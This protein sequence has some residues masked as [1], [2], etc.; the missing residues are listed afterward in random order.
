MSAPAIGALP[1]VL[2]ARVV[3]G[4]GGGPDRTIL[5]S[6]R[7]LERHGYAST[8]LYLRPPAD[9]GFAT[10][11]ERAKLWGAPLA[12]IDDRGAFDPS[13]VKRA[14]RVCRSLQPAIWHGHDYK[15]N[16]LGL[17]LK[18]RHGFRL[19]TT[20]HG[21]VNY[22]WKTPLFYAIDKACL[23]RYE[24][25]ICVS[26]GEF[27]TCLEARVPRSRLF[28]VHNSVDVDRFR[29]PMIGEGRMTR[30]D[31]R[32]VVGGIGRLEDEKG[33]DVLIRVIAALVAD[34]I[35]LELRLAGEGK[36]RTELGE[37]A[38]SLGIADRVQFC[39]FVDSIEEFHR[40]LDVFV[41]SS[42]RE[43]LPN[44]LLEAMATGT[45]SV[46]TDLPG[47]PAEIASSKGLLV[48]REAAVEPL[49]AALREFVEDAEKRERAGVAG[50][51]TIE[52]EFNFARRMERVAALYDE[53]LSPAQEPHRV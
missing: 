7:H 5:N 42:R 24:Q 16:L 34:G 41:L 38:T 51:G 27:D 52:R 36:C 40:D 29:P 47:L 18:R 37:L 13:V 6:P 44:A 32:L 48:A 23:R 39:G 11:E 33:F 31:Q 50:R 49:E 30:E 4:A 45:A 26:Q 46:T 21:W 8:C 15:S 9:E 1:H 12:A 35:D 2:H 14:D 19:V 43:G 17:L 25:V 10:L 20:V 22:T 28:L 3:C 53:L